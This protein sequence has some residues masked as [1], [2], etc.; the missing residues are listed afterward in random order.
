MTTLRPV[1]PRLTSV[2]LLERIEPSLGRALGCGER[3][4]SVGLVTCDQDDS[5]Y[6]ALDHATKFADVDVVY[7]KSFYAGAA[8]AS[9]PFSGEVLGAL[10]GPDPDQ[11][12]E[13]LWALRE[14]LTGRVHFVTLDA[15]TAPAF[16]PHVIEETGRYLAPL[17]G[18]AVGSPLAYL[19]APPT[20]AL[21]GLDAALKS[22]DV[23]L[24]RFFGPPT[25]T[26]FAGGYLTGS[27]ADV[28]AAARAFSEGV[29]SVVRAPLAGLV[30]PERERR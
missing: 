21:I 6:A 7:A 26:N 28:H 1:P 25:E 14:A 3:H 9:G 5:L 12:K 20:E 2:R 15:T 24:A 11:V 29:E 19:I 4:V 16:F 10:A 22:A 30:R 18:V 8:H 23:R 13:G 17:A 27:V